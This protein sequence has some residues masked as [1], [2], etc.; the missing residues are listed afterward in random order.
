VV[1]GPPGKPSA[2]GSHDFA[3]RPGHHLAPVTLPDG[4]GL[5]QALGQGLTLLALG[6]NPGPWATAAAELG[7]PLTVLEAPRDGDAARYGAGQVLIRP[8]LFA[9]WAGEAAEDPAAVLARAAGFA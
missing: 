4:R 9:A 1:I 2:R 3:A 5:H 6:A 7:I 8:D